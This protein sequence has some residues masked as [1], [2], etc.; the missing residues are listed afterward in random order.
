VIPALAF[1]GVQAFLTWWLPED[2]LWRVATSLLTGFG[3]TWAYVRFLEHWDRVRST[4]AA[5]AARTD[6]EGVR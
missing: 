2:S 4:G 3:L 5:P 6:R 1:A